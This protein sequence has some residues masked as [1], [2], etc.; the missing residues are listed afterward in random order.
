MAKKSTSKPPATKVRG[1]N[2]GTGEVVSL[3]RTQPAQ[4][5]LFQT[6]LPEDKQ[7][8]EYSNTIELYDAIPK[9]YSSPNRMAQMRQGGIYLPVLRHDFDHN[10]MGYTVEIT[11]A[12]LIDNDSNEKEYYPTQREEMLEAALIKLACERQNGLYLDNEAG[13]QFTLY[14]LRQELQRHGHSINYPNLVTSLKICRG[15]GLTVRKKGEGEVYLNSS[16]FP[17]L[18]LANRR[19][20]EADPKNTRCY[21][22]FNPLVTRSINKLSYRQFHYQAFMGLKNQLSRYLFKRLSHNYTQASWDQPYKILLSTI[23]RDSALVN[24]SRIRDQVRYVDAAFGE[25]QGVNAKDSAPYVLMSCEK[26]IHKGPRNKI[27]D[28]LY[29]LVPSYEFTSQMKKANKRDQHLKHE[30]TQ[31]SGLIPPNGG[32]TA[33]RESYMP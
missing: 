5:S 14:E 22:Q 11:P 3:A 18:V 17:V 32:N 21:V 25:L 8:G 23:V 12:R 29:T 2:V 33:A 26:T 7:S 30:V 28:V 10:K 20:W 13:V 1:R 31:A 27:E 24:F 9:Y 19:E 16:I 15:A 4:L 6:F